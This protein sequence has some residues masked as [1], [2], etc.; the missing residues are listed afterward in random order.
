MIDAYIIHPDGKG[1][2][3]MLNSQEPPK[4]VVV[5]QLLGPAPI[6]VDSNIANELK[7]KV[8]DRYMPYQGYKWVGKIKKFAHVYQL[9]DEY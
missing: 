2:L 8:V 5:S 1:E 4:E 6:S 3:K 7:V 9:H